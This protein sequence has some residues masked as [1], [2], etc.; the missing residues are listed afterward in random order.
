ML[1]VIE[2]SLVI[3][4]FLYSVSDHIKLGPTMPEAVTSFGECR[5]TCWYL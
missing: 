1:K 3:L 2:R 5:A 4:L